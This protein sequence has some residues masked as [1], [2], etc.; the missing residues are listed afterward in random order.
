MIVIA[1]IH[2]A[3]YEFLQLFDNLLLMAKGQIVYSDKTGWS[4]VRSVVR[5]DLLCWSSERLADY[6]ASLGYPV[7]RT[8]SRH[9]FSSRLKEFA[10][11]TKIT[12]TLRQLP[13]MS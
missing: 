12:L 5:H 3:N 9:F 8:S 7:P 11:S 1:C 2:H 4:L 10:S 13:L 6:L